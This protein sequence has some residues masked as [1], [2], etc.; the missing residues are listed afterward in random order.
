MATTITLSDV[1]QLLADIFQ[2]SK[3]HEKEIFLLKLRVGSPS[4]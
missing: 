4:R 2:H 3:R 1:G